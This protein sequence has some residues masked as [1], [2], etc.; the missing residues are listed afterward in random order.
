MAR[1]RA[2]PTITRSGLLVCWMLLVALAGW[3]LGI[4]WIAAL[5]ALGVLGASASAAGVDSRAPG[6]WTRA[7]SP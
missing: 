1:W 6:D 5:A 3:V 7:G 4:G 2:L